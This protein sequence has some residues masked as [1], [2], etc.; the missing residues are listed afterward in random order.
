MKYRLVLLIFATNFKGSF[1][2]DGIHKVGKYDI[3]LL[4]LENPIT[5]NDN[6]NYY[7]PVFLPYP[8]EDCEK[9]GKTL[10]VAGWGRSATSARGVYNKKLRRLAQQCF[11]SNKCH[12]F[13]GYGDASMTLCAGDEGVPENAACQ[14][15]DG[16]Q[17]I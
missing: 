1:K 16:G 6:P 11:P 7:Q 15:D 9:F 3:A 14:K 4:R 10:I 12:R 5:Y 2:V 17:P 13:S 8:E